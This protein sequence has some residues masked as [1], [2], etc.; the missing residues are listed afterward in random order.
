MKPNNT[1]T[2][3]QEYLA[4]AKARNRLPLPL[5]RHLHLK[6]Q[7]LRISV[8]AGTMGCMQTAHLDASSITCVNQM[9]ES[10]LNA[11]AIR[12]SMSPSS[13]V[14]GR[15]ELPVHNPHNFSFYSHAF[16]NPEQPVKILQH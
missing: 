12:Y 3:H 11:R 9:S 1:V 2:G 4:M 16:K 14:I 8:K 6:P 10:G 13:T 7:M 15:Q 5:H